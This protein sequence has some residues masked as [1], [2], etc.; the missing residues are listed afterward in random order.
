MIAPGMLPSPPITVTMSPLTV[1]GSVSSGERTPTAAPIIAPA[2]PPR[3][4]VVTNVIALVRSSPM[5]QSWAA[6]GCC[7]TALVAMPRRVR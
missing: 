2:I 5:P 3:T 1:N 4:P 6:T 7:E